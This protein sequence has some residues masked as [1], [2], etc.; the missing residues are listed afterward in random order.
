MANKTTFNK[1]MPPGTTSKRSKKKKSRNIPP[2][3]MTSTDIKHSKSAPIDCTT[4]HII[5]PKY[6][7]KNVGTPNSYRYQTRGPPR[8]ALPP[9]SQTPQPTSKSS[10][11]R[12]PQIYNHTNETTPPLPL[13]MSQTSHVDI[14]QNIKP[15]KHL[16][17][18]NYSKMK[19]T[20]ST[21]DIMD[22]VPVINT[23]N[24]QNTLP[25]YKNINANTISNHRISKSNE[26]IFIPPTPQQNGHNIKKK[27]NGRGK[28]PSMGA[29]KQL[30][31]RA[32]TFGQTA[33]NS[34]HRNSNSN[35]IH[36]N[37]AP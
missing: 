12:I 22:Y 35:Q 2:P 7:R 26:N 23:Y 20:L 10:F 25:Q 13:E 5:P 16:N 28:N 17:K 37:Q 9:V 34:I 11:N 30:I 31:E 19:K 8:K 1:P 36:S 27:S 14:T 15:T 4:S 21:N 29:M 33:R 32:E 24:R 6:K 18:P 3:V